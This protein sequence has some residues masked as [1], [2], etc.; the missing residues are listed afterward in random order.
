MKDYLHLSYVSL[1]FVILFIIVIYNTMAVEIQKNWSK[2]RCDP[3]YWIFSKNITKD[4]EI[5]SRQD[6]I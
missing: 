3:W 5:C 4:L 6:K 1:G 2:Y